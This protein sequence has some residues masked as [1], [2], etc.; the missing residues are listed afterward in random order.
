MTPTHSFPTDDGCSAA[1]SWNLGLNARPLPILPGMHLIP[2]A[3]KLRGQVLIV[4]AG[5]GDRGHGPYISAPPGLPGQQPRDC[6]Y[7]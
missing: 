7:I 6:T 5:Q 3:L 2:G 4:D 1:L